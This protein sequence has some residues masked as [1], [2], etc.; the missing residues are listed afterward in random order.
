MEE[1]DKEQQLI[2]DIKRAISRHSHEAN[3]TWAQILGILEL[4]KVEL[5]QQL[6]EELYEEDDETEED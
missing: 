6:L 3:L 1:F 2:E 4:V 5:Q